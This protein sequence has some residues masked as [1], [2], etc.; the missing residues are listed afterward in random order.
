MSFK[1]P[2][3]M[4]Q[5][6]LLILPILSFVNCECTEGK[7]E[8]SDDLESLD[9]IFLTVGTILLIISCIISVIFYR[10]YKNTNAEV[11]GQEE[12]GVVPVKKEETIYSEVIK[13]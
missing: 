4:K 6:F 5:I 2:D 10:K 11:A 1:F 3:Q 13:K 7:E 12:R 9:L 8:D